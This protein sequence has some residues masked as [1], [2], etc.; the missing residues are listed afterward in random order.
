MAERPLALEAL[1]AVP[2]SQ[3]AELYAGVICKFGDDLCE[4]S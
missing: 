4:R 3:S 2:L 1:R